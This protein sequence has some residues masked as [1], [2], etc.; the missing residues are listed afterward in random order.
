MVHVILQELEEWKK[1]VHREG[2][3]NKSP[4]Y[5]S[6][7][8]YYLP[9]N[10]LI[11]KINSE[12]IDGTKI[13]QILQESKENIIIKLTG[14]S[15]QEFEQIKL[16][17]YKYA[18]STKEQFISNMNESLNHE[19][20]DSLTQDIKEKIT[21]FLINDKIDIEQ[22]C[23]DI[24]NG[25]D[26]TAFSDELVNFVE[27]NDS[28][29]EADLRNKIYKLIAKCFICSFSKIEDNEL[30]KHALISWKCNNCGN[31]NYPQYIGGKTNCNLVNCKLCGIEQISSILIKIRNYQ[32]F[33][34]INSVNDHMQEIK[35]NEEYEDIDR[36][37]QKVI[38]AL[39]IDLKC[40]NSGKICSKMWNLAR[41]LILYKRWLFTVAAKLNDENIDDVEKTV[42]VDI[43][44]L[45]D[46]EY[47]NAFRESIES[48]NHKRFF[49]EEHKQIL[50][51]MF[52]SNTKN[53]SEFSTFLNLKDKKEFSKLIGC[54]KE[55]IR[56]FIGDKIYKKIETLLQ[57]QAAVKQF[58]TFLSYLHLNINSI[59][60][61]Y[62]HILHYHIHHGD[63]D[64]VKN[65]FRFF[66]HVV[67][68]D[69]TDGEKSQCRSLQ[70][71]TNQ[72]TMSRVDY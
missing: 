14:W 68:Y 7:V 50:L 65:T 16:L 32:S 13:S 31:Y 45:N 58:G 46:D 61:C 21:N 6:D 36:L 70:R 47:Q 66:A 22:I 63:R 37:I 12:R 57:K 52:K 27:T 18:S 69:D 40:P 51:I 4:D 72:P 48:I 24:K 1:S 67:H 30:H 44:V 2:L 43:K 20:T 55:T 29:Y 38:T 34:S 59:N 19:H 11:N 25:Y 62:H 9:L 54:S 39:Q 42:N 23:F 8:L 49:K 56:P 53:I 10:N 64:S 71:T 3:Q 26:I 33:L 15:E 17:Y 41:K 35:N 28:D 60:E 5:I